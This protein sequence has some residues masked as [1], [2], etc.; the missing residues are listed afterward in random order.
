[1]QS[2]RSL[3]AAAS[4]GLL[5]LS[6]VAVNAVVAA[7]WKVI[8]WNDLGMHCMDGD[9]SVFS[10]LPPFN[11]LQAQVIDGQGRLVTNATGIT[12]S[13]EAVA[14]PQG[15]INKSSAGKT[16]FWTFAKELYGGSSTPDTGLT[17]NN[18]PGS[19]NAPQ[20]MHFDSTA[21]KFVAEGIPITPYDDGRHIRPYPMMRVV[22]RDAGNQELAATKVVLPVSDEMDCTVCHASGSGPDAEP[23]AGW[24]WDRNWQR[25]YRLNVLR[26]HDEL[27]K[28]NPKYA[29]ALQQANY[30]SS[31][32]YHTVVNGNK[33][34]LC[35]RCHLSNA[36][37]GSGI[38]GVSPLTQAMHGFHAHVK[39]PLTN[40][41]LDDS[42]NRA[43][44]YRCHP[45]SETGCLRGAMGAAVASNGDRSMQCQDCHG[46][47]SAVGSVREGW[48]DQPAC[49][50]CHTGTAVRNN[51][52][53][54][55]TTVFDGTTRRV[56]VDQTFATNPDVPSKGFDLYR[57]SK[58]HGNLAC[59]ACHGST[60]A[61]YPSSHGNDNVQSRDLQQHVGTL[62]EC[63]SCHAQRPASG[64]NGPHGMHETGAEWVD[65]H[66]DYAEHNGTA[67]CM[68][69][70]GTD[71]RGTE[72][73]RMHDDRTFTTKFGTKRFFR[74]ANVS[75]Y[76]CHNGPRSENPNPNRPPVANDAQ[77]A[78]ATAPVQVQLVASDPDNQPLA[79]RI[80]RQPAFGRVGLQ[81]TTATYFPDP[82]F[83]GTDQFTFAAWDGAID[84]NLAT[85]SV[86]RGATANS[87]GPA[88]PGSGGAAPQWLPLQPPRLGTTAMLGVLNHLATPTSI[89]I[90]ASGER[91][92]LVS[93]F[94]GQLLTELQYIESAALPVPGLLIPLVIPNDATLTGARLYAQIVALDSGAR[95]QLAFSRGL[96]LVIGR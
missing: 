50:S 54:R 61:I 27:Q 12:V 21:R 29:A 26:L 40:K 18:M 71:Y 72:L 41:T 30:S 73:A 8:A 59:E 23:G 60:H 92:H 11:T 37:P 84:S 83:A 91:A 58:G 39:D 17:G 32:L 42:T 74:G 85:V 16:D 65:H 67:G 13:Y 38:S 53:I 80:V 68:P 90:L 55:Y 46:S 9:Y 89:A 48:L 31:G 52:Q 34:I 78:T 62:V 45:G 35:A 14:D 24:V 82:G 22:V 15:S 79:L 5:F 96:E 49:Q 64:L 51:G 47:M 4:A 88:Y 7:P 93:G 56:A 28:G 20:P 36:L 57:F 43:S 33:P 76:A 6:F 19:S 1:M 77:T 87:Y 3:L 94:G 69:C 63:M 44:C 86:T 75:C 2:R 95:Y 66:G 10:L 70:H 25:D 81:G